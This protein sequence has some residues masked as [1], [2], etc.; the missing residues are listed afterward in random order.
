[1]SYTEF[2]KGKLSILTRSTKETLDYI[3]KHDLADEFVQCGLDDEIDIETSNPKYLILHKDAKYYGKEIDCWLCEFIEHTEQEGGG[4]YFVDVKRVSINEYEFTCIF[5]NGGT[6]LHEIL[7]E[8]ISELENEPYNK[9]F[10]MVKISPRDSYMI[11][12]CFQY[13]LTHMD[14]EKLD[15]L[16]NNYSKEEIAKLGQQFGD[17]NIRNGW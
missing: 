12:D 13:V 8:K 6:C 1:M 3:K 17:M 5:Y 2:H 14:I 7:D 11:L 9:E 15:Y 16:Y 10:E 4:D